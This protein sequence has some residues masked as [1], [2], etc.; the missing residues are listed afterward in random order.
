M[1]LVR[2]IKAD[3]G[4]DVNHAILKWYADGKEQSSPP[5]QDKAEG[6]DGATAA[7]CDMAG[8]ASFFIFSFHDRSSFEFFL[9]HG[10]GVPNPTGKQ[11]L[12][13]P[14]DVVWKEA[15]A[16]GSLLKVSAQDNRTYFH[17]L[18]KKE[19][20]SERFSLIFRV[21]KTFVPIDA[22]EAANVNS[23][24]YRFVSKSQVAAGRPRPTA[25]D[26]ESA[27]QADAVAAAARAAAAGT[28]WSDAPSRKAHNHA[29]RAACEADAVREV[30]DQGTDVRER[31]GVA[32]PMDGEAAVPQSGGDAQASSSDS[33]TVRTPSEP[34]HTP[35]FPFGMP[36]LSPSSA[37]TVCAQPHS[38]TLPPLYWQV[39]ESARVG[40]SEG[41][42]TTHNGSS[43]GSSAAALGET[44][45]QLGLQSTGPSSGAANVEAPPGLEAL[46]AGAQEARAAWEAAAAAVVEAQAKCDAREKVLTKQSTELD[47][48]QKTAAKQVEGSDNARRL[49]EECEAI[50]IL[51]DAAR[52]A[53]ETAR[54]ALESQ[55]AEERRRNDELDAAVEALNDAD[56]LRRGAPEKWREMHTFGGT[57]FRDGEHPLPLPSQKIVGETD[58][59]K[60]FNRGFNKDGSVVAC[61]DGVG[62]RWHGRKAGDEDAAWVAPYDRGVADW[63]GEGGLNWLATTTGGPKEVKDT[64]ALRAGVDSRGKNATTPEQSPVHADSCWPNSLVAARAPWGD[65]HLVMITALQH[66]TQV[67]VYWFVEGGK[68][69]IVKLNAGDTFIFRGDLAHCGAEY[70]T[71]NIRI[72]CY[73]DSPCAPPTGD[74]T[75]YSVLPDSWPIGRR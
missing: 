67:V 37:V 48:R 44:A 6:V 55:Q 35:T 4:E 66:G 49:N 27:A 45:V 59:V 13:K 24:R 26:L 36:H 43:E 62:G 57:V 47:R 41:T 50:E 30:D 68:R 15:L 61:P 34:P 64:H 65:A 38:A 51:V 23:E 9:Q 8:D 14:Q 69:D 46:V 40:A 12:L 2:R 16:S 56:T 42:P 18:H 54:A 3:F 32:A 10:R 11:T 25:D 72:H 39:G 33:E 58:F 71:L 17:A 29:A 7:K 1:A 74:D 20:A 21:I 73:V 70:K 28:P 5:H 31:S 63:L 19:G 52:Q 22:A 60:I 75:T 53:T